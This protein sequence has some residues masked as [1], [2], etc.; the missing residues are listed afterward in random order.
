VHVGEYF[1]LPGRII[2][3]IASLTMPLFFVT[4][5]LLYLDRRRKK[6]QVSAARGSVAVNSGNGDSWLIGFASQSGLAE[7]LAWQSAGQL[8]AAGLP[9]QV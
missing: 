4:G 5:W 7:Q 3:T 8:Q 6:R 9:V 2:V 1:G